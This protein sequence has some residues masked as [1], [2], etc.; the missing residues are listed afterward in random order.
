M[1]EKQRETWGWIKDYRGRFGYSP[2]IH[3]IRIQ[4]GLSSPHTVASR[5]GAMERSG[6][7]TRDPNLQ[8][9][10]MI[11]VENANPTTATT[12]TNRGVHRGTDRRPSPKHLRHRA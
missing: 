11:P 3:E 2:T 7:I 12:N 9:R 4:F 1:T 5:L 10:N 6:W 8:Q